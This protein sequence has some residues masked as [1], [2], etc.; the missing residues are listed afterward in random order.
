MSRLSRAAAS[1][2]AGMDAGLVLLVAVH[3]D[4]P[5]VPVAVGRGRRPR[6][7]RA[8]VAGVGLVADQ[9]E[10]QFWAEAV[11]DVGSGVGGAVVDDE[12]VGVVGMDRAQHLLDG[13]GLVED[14]DGDERA[15]REGPFQGVGGGLGVKHGDASDRE[16]PVGIDERGG[17]CSDTLRKGVRGWG[18]GRIR[19]GGVCPGGR[20]EDGFSDCHDETLGSAHA[21]AGLGHA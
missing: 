3:R 12:D 17:S 1:R 18:G 5:V 20:G 21:D 16:E 6:A 11:E 4:D 13:G 14:G 19:F 2:K 8:A 7:W 10:A 9:V 15:H